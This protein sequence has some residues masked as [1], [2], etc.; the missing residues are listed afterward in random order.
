M[1]NQRRQHG[2]E[3]ILPNSPVGRCIVAAL[4]SVL[5]AA[6]AAASQPHVLSQDEAKRILETMPILSGNA[7]AN[8]PKAVSTSPVLI[9]SN[10]PAPVNQRCYDA[11]RTTFEQL[12]SQ[13]YLSEFHEGDDRL[14]VDAGYLTETG[15]R[16]FRTVMPGSIY[17]LVR[18]APGDSAS[19]DSVP[20]SADSVPNVEIT[21]MRREKKKRAVVEFRY[22]VSEPFRLMWS[23]RLFDGECRGEMGD[24]VV[25]EET[26]LAGHAHFRFRR[27]AWEADEVIMAVHEERE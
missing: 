1:T 26:G 6:P 9:N 24:G 23:N 8:F 7:A 11:W 16:Y 3:C 25:M 15:K 13:G 18:I 22:A 5:L 27:G 19:T 14:G 4:A 2:R 12:V 10:G 20:A 21:A 17:W